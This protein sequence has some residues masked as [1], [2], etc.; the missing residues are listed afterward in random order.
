MINTA[1]IPKSSFSCQATFKLVVMQYSYCTVYSSVVVESRPDSQRPALNKGLYC[2]SPY[3]RWLQGL[4]KLETSCWSWLTTLAVQYV[5]YTND[6]L[7]LHKIL[8]WCKSVGYLQ[9]Y[10]CHKKYW[11]VWPLSQ[12]RFSVSTICAAVMR[13]WCNDLRSIWFS[14][15]PGKMEKKRG[16][17]FKLVLKLL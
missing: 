1:N 7:L 16:F 6:V 14:G 17:R 12:V 11:F 15:A 8:Q 3:V 5:Q 9:L 2:I 10:I 13:F 4:P